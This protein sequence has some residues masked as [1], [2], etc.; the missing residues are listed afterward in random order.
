MTADEVFARSSE[1]GRCELVKGELKMMSPAGG[2]HGQ[3]A[4]TLA[5][6]LMD[7]AKKNGGVVF[8]AETGFVLE[9][10][11]DTVRAPD[12]AWISAERA[13][14]AKTIKFIP[15]P[16]DMLAEVLS[17]NDKAEEVAEKTQWWLD[18]GVRLIWIADPANRCVTVCLPGGD[19]HVYREGDTITGGDVLH[20]LKVAVKALFA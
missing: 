17:P 4:A 7:W 15:I 8:G 10:N 14:E 2:D 6:V 11:P 3:V 1:L 18:H 5:F 20:G 16:P 19:A 9:R 12:A 13:S